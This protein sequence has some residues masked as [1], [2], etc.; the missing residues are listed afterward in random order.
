MKRVTAPRCASARRPRTTL[1]VGASGG[2]SR[3][4]AR[5][6]AT[7]WTAGRGRSAGSSR[8]A[9]RR[10]AAA[11]PGELAAPEPR[12]GSQCAL[13]ER[14]S[15]R[16]GPAA[17]AAASGRP[18]GKR[19]R[20]L[21]ARGTR[22]PIDQ[23]SPTMWWKV[24]E[25]ARA[26]RRPGG[27]AWSGS[28][29]P[30]ARSNGRDASSAARRARPRGDP[31][32]RRARRTGRPAQDRAGPGPAG[33]LHRRGSPLPT[34]RTWCAATRGGAQL[35]DAALQHARCPAC[36][37][38]GRRRRCCRPSCSGSSWSRNH[39]RSWEK[40]SGSGGAP[41]RRG[42]AA[43][44]AL[45][46]DRL[47]DRIPEARGQIARRLAQEVLG[48]HS[49]QRSAAPA[50]TPECWWNFTSPSMR[51]SACRPS[52][53]RSERGAVGLG[54]LGVVV[55]AGE[56][57]DPPQLGIR[58]A[59]Q[60][61]EAHVEPARR[62]HRRQMRQNIALCQHPHQ[63]GQLPPLERLVGREEDLVDPRLLEGADHAV[64]VAQEVDVERPVERLLGPRRASGSQRVGGRLVDQEAVT[65]PFLE[66]AV[67]PAR[68]HPLL[69]PA[70]D[71]GRRFRGIAAERLHD[72]AEQPFEAESV[73]PGEG[74]APLA[75]GGEVQQLQLGRREQ[76]RDGRPA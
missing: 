56:G 71:E 21:P 74:V 29:G 16:T 40:E 55:E 37:A 43:Q 22:M 36:R 34:S 28:S 24:S 9:A 39:R 53:M 54:H 52:V 69:F 3:T 62:G 26:R 73:A 75:Q 66:P 11:P 15:R 17:R 30:C 49:R 31:R 13:P 67:E 47:G 7:V 19:G 32:A 44:A 20:A 64:G 68:C 51:D 12:P 5:R 41:S 10:R 33:R 57:A 59:H 61:L 48:H 27:A 45:H 72:R 18:S 6:R 60:I 2:E 42:M 76:A 38:G 23:P 1:G 4:R 35:G 58:I 46:R 63:L 65:D 25:Q 8:P 50:S 14:R 70:G